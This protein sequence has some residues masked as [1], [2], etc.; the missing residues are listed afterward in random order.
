ML[1]Y[2]QRTTSMIEGRY[3]SN[4]EILLVFS[5]K[6]RQRSMYKQKRIEYAIEVLNKS[7]PRGKNDT[8]SRN[9]RI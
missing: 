1:K 4:E 9:F 6:M 7:P 8:R 5:K 2:L 3:V